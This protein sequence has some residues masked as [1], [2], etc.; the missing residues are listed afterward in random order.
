M[1]TTLYSTEWCPACNMLKSFLDSKNIEYDLQLIGKD[2]TAEE[3]TAKTNSQSVPVLDV[4]DKQVVGLDMEQ[5]SK[6]LRI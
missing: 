6:L 4:D 2:L 1:T 3:F 5:I